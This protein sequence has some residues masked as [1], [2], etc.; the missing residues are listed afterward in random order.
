[1]RRKR[2]FEA[3]SGDLLDCETV[4]QPQKRAEGVTTRRLRL[5]AKGDSVGV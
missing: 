3:V 2:I 4:I 1:M 5:N